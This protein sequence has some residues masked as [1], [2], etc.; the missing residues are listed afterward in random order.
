MDYFHHIPADITFPEFIDKF[1]HL[2]HFLLVFYT[3]ISHKFI[4]SLKQIKSF[5]RLV[6]KVVVLDS[7]QFADRVH[8]K[9]GCADIHRP[10]GQAG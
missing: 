5:E 6:N 10:D 8:G 1:Y 7:A 9:D 3:V 4:I 2:F